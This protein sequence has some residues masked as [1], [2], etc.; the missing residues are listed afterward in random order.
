M[1]VL[2]TWTAH[3][4]REEREREWRGLNGKASGNC[5]VDLRDPTRLIS[6]RGL[7]REAESTS[8]RSGLTRLWR[9]DI[10][11]QVKV[12]IPSGSCLT[13]PRVWRLRVRAQMRARR[14]PD[15]CSS[16]SFRN[17]Y[18]PSPT[19]VLGVATSTV[20]FLQAAV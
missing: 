4:N 11:L 13:G 18:S 14:L 19:N 1:V 3:V 20:G 17:V 12:P 16:L 2:N 9:R 8:V 7:V 5:R 6:R 15:V 10:Y